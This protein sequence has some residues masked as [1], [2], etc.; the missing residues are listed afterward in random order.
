M[1]VI[2]PVNGDGILT[3]SGESRYSTCLHLKQAKL[4]SIAKN[5]DV[6]IRMDLRA[7]S[8]NRGVNV[9]LK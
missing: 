4:S 6:Y 3:I 5:A 2:S 9:Y 1:F 8:E 7:S